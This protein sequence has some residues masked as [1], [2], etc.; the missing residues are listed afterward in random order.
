MDAF[1]F[2]GNATIKH[3]NPRKEGPEEEKNLAVDIKLNGTV[4]AEVWDYFHEDIKPCLYTDAGTAK[5]S[6]MESIGFAHSVRNCTVMM[7]ER[8][9]HGAE[10]KN[11]KVRPKDGWLADL[12]FSV[13][14]SPD[15][16]DIALLAEYLQEEVAVTVLPQPDLFGD[17]AE[18]P[19]HTGAP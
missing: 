19:G 17:Q 3:I 12:T 15:G 11:F 6:M 9:F 14:I 10:V 16:S 18:M 1:R 13:T 8:I 7:L 2:E 5:N 4:P